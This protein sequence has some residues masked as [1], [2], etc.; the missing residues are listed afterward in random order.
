MP[1][2]FL[3]HFP[4][5]GK[6][7]VLSSRRGL[8]V[9]THGRRPVW[10]LPSVIENRTHL[11]HWLTMRESEFV[12]DNVVQE[13]YGLDRDTMSVDSVWIMKSGK[14][15]RWTEANGY[16]RAQLSG[17]SMQAEVTRNFGLIY[18]VAVQPML[19]SN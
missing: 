10:A 5:G 15:Y 9:L 8:P 7:E 4:L 1:R 12:R 19:H 6:A 16:V 13:F 2:R 3:P 17:P 18:L 14:M 11:V